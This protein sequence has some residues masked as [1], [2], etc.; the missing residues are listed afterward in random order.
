MFAGCLLE[1]GTVQLT[2]E[3]RA[4]LRGRLQLQVTGDCAHGL[5]GL[6]AGSVSREHHVE[7][8]QATL[9]QP[10]VKIGDFVRSGSCAFELLVAGVV[11]LICRI[12]LLF[13]R[14]DQTFK[15]K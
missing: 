6:G 9:L 10:G 8:R 13:V 4:R 3:E 1:W 2:P 15:S 11:A 7:I 5:D 12:S 14:T